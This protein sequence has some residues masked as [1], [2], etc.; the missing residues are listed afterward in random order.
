MELVMHRSWSMPVAQALQRHSG[1][2][3]PKPMGENPERDDRR[4]TPNH[5]PEDVQRTEETVRSDESMTFTG[6]ALDVCP[7]P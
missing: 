6:P 7:S 2:G 1:G 3:S 5:A 4:S